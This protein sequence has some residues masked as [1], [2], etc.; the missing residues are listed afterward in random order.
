MRRI[1]TLTASLIASTI[2]GAV[3]LA[4]TPLAAATP[5]FEPG[6]TVKRPVPATVTLPV[7]TMPTPGRNGHNGTILLRVGASQPIRVIVDTGFSGLLLFPGVWDRTPAG[8]RMG[9]ETGTVRGPNGTRIKGVRGTA[10]MAFSGVTTTEAIPFLASNTPNAYLKQ[11]T[12]MGVY[13]LL[14]V[15]TKGGA[16]MVNP[17]TALPGT[18]G[19]QWSIHFSRTKGTAG[20]VVLGAQPPADALMNF[21]LT[22]IGT[23]TVD[24][25]LW[26]DQ[27][28]T[29]C[30][31]FAGGAESCVDTWFDA[32]FTLMRVVGDDFADLPADRQGYLT[33]GTEVTLAAPGAA[34]TGHAFTAGSQASRNLVKVIANGD[35]LINTGNSF[36]FDYT[37]YYDLINGRIS[38]EG[39]GA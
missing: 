32:A 33:T 25:P 36:Y 14:G 18:L 24:A 6:L 37:L 12:D 22:Y 9:T 19:R 15:G 28:A 20:A 17:F 39:K 8:V 2:A 21:P 34:F 27:A 7:R 13:G 35:P 11:W 1:A 31:T 29:G 38:L 26:N 23:N 16:T 3:V 5:A 4:G 10:T 30:W